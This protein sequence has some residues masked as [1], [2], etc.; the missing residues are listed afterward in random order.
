MINKKD[1]QELEYLTKQRPPFTSPPDKATSVG[2]QSTAC[3]KL[4]RKVERKKEE[5]DFTFHHL[6]L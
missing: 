4:A 1:E 2:Y 5:L 3:T 6:S